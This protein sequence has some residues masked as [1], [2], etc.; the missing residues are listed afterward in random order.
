MVFPILRW[1]RLGGLVGTPPNPWQAPAAFGATDAELV[2][3]AHAD[4]PQDP[5]I[6][7]EYRAILCGPRLP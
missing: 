7:W 3:L 5:R 2:R 1:P 4:S 6:H